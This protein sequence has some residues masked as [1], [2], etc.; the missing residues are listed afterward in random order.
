MHNG[1]SKTQ[2]NLLGEMF[3]IFECQST[4]NLTNQGSRLS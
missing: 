4:Q 2:N 3:C 1:R